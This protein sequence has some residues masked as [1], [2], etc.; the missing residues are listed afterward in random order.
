MK[1]ILHVTRAVCGRPHIEE[2]FGAAVRA[3]K[4]RLEAQT[5]AL[6]LINERTGLLEIKNSRG[7][8]ERFIN[9]YPREIGE[10]LLADV[11]DGGNCVFVEDCTQT[12]CSDLALENKPGSLLAIPL[13]A[14]GRVMGY[15][16]VDH[17]EP[18][19]FTEY[20]RD[21]LCLIGNILALALD[22]ERYAEQYRRLH[23]RD[24]ETGLLA[25]HYFRERL[26]SEL[27]RARRDAE[28][29][30]ALLIAVDNLREDRKVNGREAAMDDLR[31]LVGEIQRAVRIYDNAGRFGPEEIL[32][33]LP[34]SGIDEAQT[35][36]TRILDRLAKSYVTGG[37]LEGRFPL[38]V[39]IGA[40]EISAHSNL[41]E[42]LEAL[43]S[44]LHNAR[45]TDGTEVGRPS[46]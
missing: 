1:E 30:S 29:L 20:Q 26:A 32:V 19:H 18:G 42:G 43:Q 38:H 24:D 10:G 17:S 46:A 4:H 13:Q 12:D 36:G 22:R 33:Y 7:L 5:V 37:A 3:I 31:D 9:H 27:R 11:I 34:H 41:T 39:A 21:E 2:S 14:Q 15:L 25:P 44:A 35:V 23:H 16:H 28:P 8:S 40:T 6:V 45:K